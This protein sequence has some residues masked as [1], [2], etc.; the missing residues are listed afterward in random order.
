MG[1]RVA[2]IVV[3]AALLASPAP[4]AR[5]GCARLRP[6]PGGAYP[7]APRPARRTGRPDGDARGLAVAAAADRRWR[8]RRRARPGRRPRCRRRRLPGED[9]VG[10]DHPRRPHARRPGPRRIGLGP[11]RHA[12]ALDRRRSAVGGGAGIP[13]PDG[14]GVAA[15]RGGHRGPGGGQAAVADRTAAPGDGGDRHAR[16]ADRR[17]ALGPRRAAQ[18]GRCCRPSCASSISPPGP[19]PPPCRSTATPA[20]RCSRRMASSSTCST[21]ASRTTIPTRT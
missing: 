16:R 9:P 3:A 2:L 19:S 17:R 1:G 5:S 21:A 7:H 10:G 14:R 4:S 20:G 8:P 12:D 11:R 6:R 13:G 15:E 18:G